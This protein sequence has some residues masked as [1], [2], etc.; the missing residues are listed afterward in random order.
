MSDSCERRVT[1]VSVDPSYAV[2]VFII[3]RCGKKPFLYRV[4]PG[5]PS[6]NG[7]MFLLPEIGGE[8]VVDALSLGFLLGASRLSN[9]ASVVI[10]G[11]VPIRRVIGFVERHG[12]TVLGRV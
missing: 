9:S 10:D 1:E 6:G 4:R 11:N 8:F 3:P 5:M 7:K 12:G 2:A